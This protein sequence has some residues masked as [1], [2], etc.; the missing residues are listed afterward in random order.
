MNCLDLILQMEAFTFRGDQCGR[1]GKPV[2]TYR[3]KIA[4]EVQAT[5]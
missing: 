3:D 4:G 5:F 1:L 2:T